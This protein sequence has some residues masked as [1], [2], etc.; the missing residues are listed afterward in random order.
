[1]VDFKRLSLIGWTGSTPLS[2]I[3]TPNIKPEYIHV[4][5]II[6]KAIHVKSTTS[7]SF[8]GFGPAAVLCSAASALKNLPTSLSAPIEG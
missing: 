6:D 8:I 2:L 4:G 5:G 3:S 7:L 1:M